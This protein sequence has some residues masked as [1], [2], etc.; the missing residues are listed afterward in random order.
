MQRKNTPQVVVNRR[1]GERWQIMTINRTSDG[2]LIAN[3]RLVDEDDMP[4]LD[5]SGF[6]V[7]HSLFL[8]QA[9]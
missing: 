7:V 5:E 1:T 3:A 8:G 2:F 4:L 6:D 9:A